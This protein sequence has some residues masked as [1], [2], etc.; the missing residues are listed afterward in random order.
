MT[1]TSHKPHTALKA[2]VCVA[3]GLAFTAL[4]LFVNTAI[5]YIP[6]IAYVFVL[7]ASLVYVHI[8]ERGVAYEVNDGG[9]ECMRGDASGF[10][11]TVSNR[12]VLPAIRI[13][14]L[15]FLS[16][17]FGGEGAVEQHDIALGPRR[18]KVYDF[19]I[20]FDHIGTYQVGVKRF[21]VSDL[22][23]VFSSVHV[24]D[25]LATMRVQPRLFDVS[26]LPLSTDSALEAKKDFTTVLNDGMDYSSVREYQ[27][28]DP[29]KTIHWKLSSRMPEGEYLTRL[30]ETNANP[31]IA[32]IADFDAPV[33]TVEELMGIY[34]AIVECSFSLERYAEQNGLDAELIFQD[35]YKM[36][37][38]FFTPLAQKRREIL[39]CM[40]K[41]YSPGSGKEALALIR[42]ELKSTFAQYNLAIC[43][44]VISKELVESLVAA[45]T[46]KRSLML[47]AV[48]PETVGE[49]R[50][51]EIV[52]CLR[53]LA[54]AGV[55]YR[56]ISNATALAEGER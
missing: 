13:E 30:Y 2:V 22:I 36:Q 35:K 8:L 41:I 16:D 29:I 11:L 43:T 38:R 1:M 50:K 56:M 6:I 40:P 32:I 52:E 20:R 27:W 4:A 7:L 45:K 33:Y 48:V 47:F 49:D 19:G 54:A 25:N 24:N 14:A 53:P 42:S 55:Y 26:D 18:D 12:S 28:G 15:F 17:L 23:G 5:G 46:G 10:T 21:A 34:D 39:E 9:G 31:G 37:R 51:K 44:S 3:V